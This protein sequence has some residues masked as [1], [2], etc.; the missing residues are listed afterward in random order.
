MGRRKG[1]RV[2]SG[3]YVFVNMRECVHLTYKHD[4]LNGEI[5]MEGE[6]WF[7]ME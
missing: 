3:K 2:L 1:R 6:Y 5:L 4:S 7:I